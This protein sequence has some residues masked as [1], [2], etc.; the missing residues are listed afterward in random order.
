M[1]LK[2]WIGVWPE[3]P[4]LIPTQNAKLI[5]QIYMKVKATQHLH[6]GTIGLQFNKMCGN[7]FLTSKYTDPSDCYILLLRTVTA[8]QLH[9]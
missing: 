8:L 7:T 6:Q 3:I 2:D 5:T 9:Y 4:L 1:M